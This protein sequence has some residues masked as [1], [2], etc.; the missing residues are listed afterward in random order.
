[1]ARSQDI[2][3]R[4]GVRAETSSPATGGLSV[5]YKLGPSERCIGVFTTDLTVADTEH[6]RDAA[7]NTLEDAGRQA[8]AMGAE[9]IA[10]G[11][12]GLSGLD[13]ELE[14][15]LGIPVVDSVRA[16]VQMAESLVRLGKRTSKANTF[17]P[18]ELKEFKGYEPIFQP[19]R[20]LESKFELEPA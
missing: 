3:L 9:A 16:S 4:C 15:R 14:A 5:I 17:K 13:V 6:L 12:A 8:I 19:K 1:M 7:C 10:L 18:P 11:C 2:A 20:R